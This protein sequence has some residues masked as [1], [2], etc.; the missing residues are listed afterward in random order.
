M[1]LNI[2]HHTG[3]PTLPAQGGA[4]TS[5]EKPWPDGRACPA[6]TSRPALTLHGGGR[7]S[8]TGHLTWSWSS[9]LSMFFASVPKALSGC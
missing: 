9:C 7:A 8:E 5:I 6:W 2:P 3:Q 4:H 1:L